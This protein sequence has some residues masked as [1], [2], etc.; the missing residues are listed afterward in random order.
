MIRILFLIRSL[1]TGGAE[2]QLCNLVKGLDK[3]MFDIYVITFYDG[4]RFRHELEGIPEIHLISLGKKKRWDLLPLF[5][6]LFVHLKKIRPQILHGYMEVPNLLCLL[7]GKILGVK[8]VWGVRSSYMN[9]SEYSWTDRWLS[10]LAVWFSRI[11][12]LIISNSY[13]GKEYSIQSG[14]PSENITVI[15]NGIDINKYHP[16]RMVGNKL[17]ESCR[18]D[19]NQLFVGMVGRLDPIKDHA[20]FIKAAVLIVEQNPSVRFVLIGSGDAEY[21]KGIERMINENKLSKKVC[22]IEHLDDM[23][24]AYNS[25]DISCLSS[26]GEGFPNTLAEAM[27]CGIP[28][29]TTDVGD[30]KHIIG[31]AGIVVP[32]GDH[33]G[34]AAGILKIAAMTQSERHELG[35][36]GRARI[37]K[38]FSLEL[39]VSHTENVIRKLIA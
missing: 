4:G 35:A 25:L 9:L 29:V 17:R 39:M 19:D 27:A 6:R 12:D 18:I 14:F 5:Y 15:N 21:K 33:N 36:R 20:T 8:V 38:N 13:A 32:V 11:P 2:K 37:V 22:L 26:Y 23:V 28:V 30:A 16:N 3:R 7:M 1:D 10:K 24:A 34:L 31:D